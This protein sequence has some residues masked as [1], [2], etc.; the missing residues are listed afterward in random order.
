MTLAHASIRQL[1]EQV[2]VLET[3]AARPARKRRLRYL[4]HTVV[5]VAAAAIGAASANSS[6]PSARRSPVRVAAAPVAHLIDAPA[7]R[8]R[9]LPAP[10]VRAHVVRH[11]M[12]HVVARVEVAL[13][14]HV[15]APA[16]APPVHV[17]APV[18]VARPAVHTVPAPHVTP[19]RPVQHGAVQRRASQRPGPEPKPSAAPVGIGPVVL[20]TTEEPLPDPAGATPATTP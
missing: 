8:K 16:A 11:V 9:A 10:R 18:A 12:H 14:V 6:H 1:Y 13:P 20:T 5:L 4:P 17:A 2:R 15:A 7:E 3:E 19:P